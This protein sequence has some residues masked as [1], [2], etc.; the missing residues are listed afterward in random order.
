MV[1]SPDGFHYN[2]NQKYLEADDHKTIKNKVV[3]IRSSRRKNFLINY[4]F[5]N[6]FDDIIFLA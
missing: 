1:F 4:R 2:L 6:K 5:L 3:I